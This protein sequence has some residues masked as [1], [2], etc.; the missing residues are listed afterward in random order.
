MPLLYLPCHPLIV[1][2]G[3]CI[4][5]G[6]GHR[7]ADRAEPEQGDEGTQEPALLG[8]MTGVLKKEESQG[9]PESPAKKPLGGELVVVK[10]EEE[11]LRALA[12]AIMTGES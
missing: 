12:A 10:V 11:K 7:A 5:T 9:G 2:R 3:L 4:C 1:S 6:A 8:D